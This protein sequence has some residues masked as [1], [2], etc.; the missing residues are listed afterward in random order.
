MAEVGVLRVSLGLDSAN[1]TRSLAEVNRKLKAV[2]SEFKAAGGSIKG[3]ENT[4]EG[5]QAKSD[6]LTKKMA[7]Q[8]A[9]VQ[10][11]KRRYEESAAT[12]GKEAAETEKLLIQYNK[13]VGEL[14]KLENELQQTSAKLDKLS[15]DV[16]KNVTVWDKMHAKLNEVGQRMQDLGSRMQSAGQGIAMS[17]GAV[18]TAIGGAL[19]FAVKKSMDFEA[20]I[21]RVGAIAG[22]TPAE[23]EKLKKSALDLG[24]STSKSATEVAQAQEIMATMGYKTNQ[25]IAAMP[26]VIAAAEA[27]GE[28]MALVADTVSAALNAF[29]L[30]ADKASK[31]ADVLAQ[32][33][34]DS[35][36]GIQD[37]Q[38][39]F[40]YAAPI[41]NQLGI[42][43]EQLAAAT[44]I[45]A[46]SGIKGEQAGT[47]L[48]AA[49]IRLSDPPKAAANT[50]HDLG[51]KITDSQG[52]MLPFSKII[53]QIKNKTEGMSNAQKAAALS[54]IFGTEAV[55]GMMAVV[56]AGPQ[57]L[58]ALTKSL[59]NSV[60][61]SQEA[62][63]KMKDNL[64]GALE[65]LSGAFETA[66]ITIGNALAPAIQKIAEAL[67]G[68]IEWFNQLSPATQ[69]FIAIGAA[70]AAVLTGI[71]AAFGVVLAVIGA[72]ASGIG[73][74]T[75]AFGAVSGAIAAAGGA[76]AIITGPIGIAVA[77]I[78]GL[79][80]AGVALWKNWDT[81]KAKATEIWGAIK[82]WFSSTLESI[83]QSFN[84]AW[85]NIKS[86]TS[87]TWQTIKQVTVTV[88]NA[89]KSAALAIIMPFVNG[90]TN[91]FNGMK[92]GLQQIFNGL[93]QYFDGVW[94]L[95][96]NIFLGAILLIIDL[97]T[98]NFKGLLNDA[99]AIFNNLKS[100]LSSIWNGIKSIFSGAVS[101]IKGFVSA[102]WGN[103]KS[104]TSSVFNTVKSL[105]SSV[106]NGIK[107]A[108]STA[109]NTAKSTVSSAFSTMKSTVSS[110][111]S[112]IKSTIT[113]MWNSAVSYLKGINLYAIGKDIIQGLAN[114]ISSMASAVVEKVKS[115]A[116]SVTTT[117]RN[118]LDIHSPSRE[119]EKLGK[120]TTEGFA[121]GIESQKKYVEQS[122]KKTAEAARKSFEQAFRNIQYRFDAKKINAKQAIDEFEKL[123][124]QYATV[125]NAVERVN[126]EIY[127]IQ[128]KYAKQLADANKKAFNEAFAKAQTNFKLGKINSS[129]YIAELRKIQKEYAKTPDQVRKVQLEIKK[130]EDQ[131]AKEQAALAKKQFEDAKKA[132]ED[133]RALGQLSLDQELK[134]WQALAKKYKEGS[135]ER[136]EIEKEIVRVKNELLK[137][138]FEKEKAYIDKRKYYNDLSLTEVLKLYESYI[139]KYKQGTEEREYYEQQI[140][141]VKKEIND[142]LLEA[143]DEY[144]KQVKEINERLYQDELKAKEE[145][146]QKVKEI[147]ERLQEDELKAKE[148]Y[149]QKVKEI[150]DRLI[151]EEQK[152]TEEYEKAV[153]D[154]T[155]SLY[156][157]AGIFDE[158]K[159]KNDVTGQGLLQ[160][161]SDQVT[162]FKDWQ[163]NIASLAARGIDE[164]L[165]QELQDMGPK[166]VDEIAALNS[167][168]DEE[169]QQYVALWREKNA[170][171]KTQA[172]NE[173]E[174]MRQQ[175]QEKIQQ[176]R[177]TASIELEQVKA[178]FVNKITELRAQAN[179][180]LEKV[181]TDYTNKIAQLRAQANAELEQH[182]NEWMAKIKEISEG[183][184]TELN[185]MSAS[186][187]DIGKNSMQGLID[188]LNSMMGPLQQKA[189]EI[190]SVVQ[191]TIK[192]ALKINSPSRVMRDEIGKWIPLGLAEG[193]SR[194]ISAVVSATNRMAQATIPAV[195]GSFG[196]DATPTATTI[197]I[198]KMAGAKIEQHF[199]FHSTAPTPSEV[200]RKTRQVS[201]QL[202]MEWGL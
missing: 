199:H 129:E 151:E 19:G 70:V 117:I 67:Q 169:L 12:K 179:A 45:M 84:N 185:L 27:S 75:T 52:K 93:K 113:D 21:D 31:V 22:A 61:A 183:T 83:K 195:A 108:I 101:A 11:L 64:K 56:E 76:M 88:W 4:L 65:N 146:E 6:M 141:R 116:N 40:K 49:L 133:K 87:S 122:S 130:I 171:A 154:R 118:V 42:S 160:N 14:K 120:N 34:N 103:I 29:G 110:I 48:R 99:K 53:E 18:T 33:A 13:A 187:A 184:K 24:A 81:V 1:F 10:E 57:K 107:S 124:K 106:W 35:A 114:G 147:N 44:E 98:G 111:M 86:F 193:I 46:N 74:L 51:V 150:N 55:S 180:E 59:Q 176:L 3:F 148:E 50:L 156:N 94:K 186:M 128:Q 143:N 163:A 26:G 152:L 17:F 153:E 157:F 79:T 155:K 96:K 167:L 202:A 38:Y 134:A 77:A 20:Q 132:I 102:A 126:K 100:A 165:L 166:A 73:A 68:L 181:K 80:V 41:A 170:L 25:I 37:M 8:S 162:A 182:K 168:S 178:E 173:L 190:A 123:K 82:E 136:I 149:E 91:L 135:K 95:I 201:R 142:K 9:R 198:P 138:Q 145:Y 32:A 63:Q 200:A 161:L 7:L 125:P 58:D 28:D 158:F 92:G 47:T 39:T 119:T 23:L 69:K 191:A 121:K 159:R 97:V 115:I 16:N 89:I 15:Q 188:G 60:G 174:G 139:K 66:Q 137:Q 127:R 112:G 105:A 144:A 109:V 177:Y 140:Y 78:A 36:A 71:V 192:D 172:I 194:N 104:T 54:A 5:L 2:E 30:S 197:N 175:T 189:R 72:A 196:R 131:R 90:I 85:N 164:G 43:L 62:A